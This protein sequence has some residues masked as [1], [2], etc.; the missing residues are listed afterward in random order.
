M[1]PHRDVAGISGG[2]ERCLGKL[3]LVDCAVAELAAPEKG[4]P[5]GLAAALR[6][7]HA[8]EARREL[9]AIGALLSRII[10]PVGPAP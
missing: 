1:K 7:H 6:R 10:A 3:R 5:R 4:L 9:H 8:R 2:L